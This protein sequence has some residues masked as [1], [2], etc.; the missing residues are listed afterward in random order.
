MTEAGARA[1]LTPVRR[2]SGSSSGSG[3][4]ERAGPSSYPT[5]TARLGPVLG[6]GPKRRSLVGVTEEARRSRAQRGGSAWH[7]SRV[8]F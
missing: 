1:F 3:V 7:V 4:V 6:E 5:D 2:S 8:V